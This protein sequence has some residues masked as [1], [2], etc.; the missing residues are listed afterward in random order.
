MPDDVSA[1]STDRQAT[2]VVAAS[3]TPLDMAR[4]AQVRGQ[5]ANG[6]LLTR[7]MPSSTMEAWLARANPLLLTDDYAPVDNLLA[8]LFLERG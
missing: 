8:P 6:R 3:L 7:I 2:F 4:L 1:F 5:A